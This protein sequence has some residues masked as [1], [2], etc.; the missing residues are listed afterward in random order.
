MIVEYSYSPQRR[1]SFIIITGHMHAACTCSKTHLIPVNILS[2]QSLRMAEIQI[3]FMPLFMYMYCDF[4]G[5]FHNAKQLSDW[6]LHFIS[7]NF[8]AF[9]KRTE[10]SQLEGDNLDYVMRNRWPPVIYLQEMQEFELKHKKGK[11][12][13]KCSVM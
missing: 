1:Y 10:F 4:P 6:C 2:V 12:K 7:S 9:E 11:V 3:L 8:L 5:Q 13:K